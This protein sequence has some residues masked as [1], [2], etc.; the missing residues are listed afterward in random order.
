MLLQDQ[1]RSWLQ[2]MRIGQQARE[3]DSVPSNTTTVTLLESRPGLWQESQSKHTT[4]DSYSDKKQASFPWRSWGCH[5]RLTGA[6]ALVRLASRLIGTTALSGVSIGK[7][8]QAWRFL[9][10]LGLLISAFILMLITAGQQTTSLQP[11]LNNADKS[12]SSCSISWQCAR[13][14]TN[15]EFPT[16]G[17]LG[18]KPNKAGSG[19]RV[20]V[21]NS[22]QDPIW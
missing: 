6:S 7:K 17:S 19:R 13:I 1:Q 21:K 18:V 16:T 20:P 4:L 11:W 12:Y 14:G 22:L 5:F 15:Q 9:G 2:K 8:P 10:C 3:T